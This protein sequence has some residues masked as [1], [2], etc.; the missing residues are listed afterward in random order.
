MA[1][2]YGSMSGTKFKE[3]MDTC[4]DKHNN[5]TEEGISKLKSVFNTI[6]IKEIAKT[7]KVPNA[8]ST[9]IL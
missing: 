2:N 9:S 7:Y 6:L 4:V 1:S 3:V 8:V 5:L